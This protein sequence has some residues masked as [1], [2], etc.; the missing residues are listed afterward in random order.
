M[1]VAVRADASAEM[2]LGHLRRC[3][4]LARALSARGMET[5]FVS[6]DLGLDLSFIVDAGFE[7]V[8]LPASQHAYYPAA[9]DP[10]HA[11]WAGITADTDAAETVTALRDRP[12]SWV[13]VDHYAFGANWHRMIAKELQV[14]LAVL[15]DLADRALDA[16]LLIDHNLA[17]DHKLKYA[18]TGSRIGRLLGGPRY[19]LLDPIYRDATRYEFHS[20]V[21]SVGIFVGGTD[22]WQA[23][24][25]ALEGLRHYCAFHGLIEIATTRA[26]PHLEAL[27]AVCTADGAARLLVDQPGLQD[28][29]ARHDLQIGAGG[30][31]ALERCC[32]GAPTLLLTLADNQRSG[33]EGLQSIGAARVVAD[34]SPAAL[35]H[36]FMELQ[37]DPE[38]RRR[39]SQAGRTLVDG[40]GTRRVAV[41]IGAEGLDLRAATFADAD[42]C[43][44]WRNA[45]STRRYSRDPAP[46]TLEH[47]RHWW[48]ATLSDPQ[49]LLL[50][51]HV[52]TDAVGVVRLDLTGDEAEVSIYTDPD[53]AGLGLGRRML[54]AVAWWA[55]SHGVGARTL[56]AE[57]HPLNVASQRSFAAANFCQ[58]APRRWVR[59]II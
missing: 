43:L 55:I 10:A 54:D 14:K 40:Q 22:P 23:S 57:I 53:L 27:R 4:S 25:M 6:R 35:A 52:G 59:R 31:A 5:V 37:Q 9:G 18:S 20:S 47:H 3:L 12:L 16:D 58:V 21:R 11:H 28:F 39:M 19:A 50:L 7:L 41:T 42:P 45:P 1:T 51:A 24:V 8:R 36:A 46:V 15:D 26:N 32:I 29:F 30:G 44:A 34:A 38:N 2:G 17:I 56:I 48:Q 33:A 13:I 49:R